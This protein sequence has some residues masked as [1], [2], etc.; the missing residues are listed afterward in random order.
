MYLP[1]ADRDKP[2]SVSDDPAA[3]AADW[4]RWPQW[5]VR[6]CE[7]PRPSRRAPR[8]TPL[9]RLPRAS[10]S[11][12]RRYDEDVGVTQVGAV[13]DHEPS[14]LQLRVDVLELK[15]KPLLHAY[16]AVLGNKPPLL[17]VTVPFVGAVS[18]SHVT[19]TGVQVRP[20]P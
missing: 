9:S 16:V 4:R 12:H 11:H 17:V 20:S 10:P 18:V 5:E 14:A 6:A 1:S 2:P 15:M 3:S 13:P 7:Q 8:G 19:I